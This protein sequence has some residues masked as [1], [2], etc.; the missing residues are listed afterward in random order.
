MNAPDAD[1]LHVVEALR[2]ELPAAMRSGAVSGAEGWSLRDVRTEHVF[3]R[4]VATLTLT[5]EG[6]SLRAHL[7]PMHALAN[8][9]ARIRH[10][11]LY[12]L[13]D[14]LPGHEPAAQALLDGLL[15]WLDRTLVGATNVSFLDPAAPEAPAAPP[16]TAAVLATLREGLP[17]LL[18]TEA[19]A[20]WSLTRLGVERFRRMYVPRIDLARAGNNALRLFLLPRGTEETCHF[21]TERFDMVYDD[22]ARGSTYSRNHAVMEHF[23]AG[24]NGPSRAIGARPRPSPRRRRGR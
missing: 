14:L 23:A 10:F 4:P 17:A 2:A 13:D 15:H 20:G 5:R 22:D 24:G 7:F 12:H 18:A 11:D 21:H 6:H 9:Y 1:A 16:E 8:P 19:L 3:E